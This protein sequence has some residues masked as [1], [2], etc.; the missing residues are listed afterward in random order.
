MGLPI[1]AFPIF[2]WVASSPCYPFGVIDPVPDIAG[3]AAEHD[4]LCHVDAC[5]GGLILPWWERL[6][7]PVP[8]WDFRVPGV[9]SLSAGLSRP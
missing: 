4:V 8:P 1:Q 7:Q 9:T 2:I 3:L 6:G 5:L